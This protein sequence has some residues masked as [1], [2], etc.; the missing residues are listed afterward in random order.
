MI[1]DLLEGDEVTVCYKDK[2]VT[3]T[4]EMLTR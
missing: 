2:C 1:I 3:I 4:S